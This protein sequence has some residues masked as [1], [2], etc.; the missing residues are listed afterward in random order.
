GKSLRPFRPVDTC[1]RRS[2]FRHPTNGPK[3]QGPDRRWKAT[4]TK[5]PPVW[6]RYSACCPPEEG[7]TGTREGAGSTVCYAALGGN[8]AVHRDLDNLN[9]NPLRRRRA[10]HLDDGV[11]FSG[12]NGLDSVDG[13]TGIDV[14][15]IRRRCAV[16]RVHVEIA[17]TNAAKVLIQPREQ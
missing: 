10:L 5:C 4:S 1:F 15:R 14:V 2:R 8:G 12:C 9:D 11:D 17:L 7:A 3:P 16:E 6:E 13:R